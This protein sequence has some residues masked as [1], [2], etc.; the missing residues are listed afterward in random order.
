MPIDR[1]MRL[2]AM[3]LREPTDGSGDDREDR[4]AKC[5]IVGLIDERS[6]SVATGA[7]NL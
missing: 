1:W 3:D 6:R 2:H 7:H 4:I 5:R